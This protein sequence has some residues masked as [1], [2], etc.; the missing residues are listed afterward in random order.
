ME[1]EFVPPTESLEL[2]ELGFDDD[3]ICV[4]NSFNHLKGVIISSNN[5][6]Y[7]KKDK[8]DDRLPAP[9]ISQAFRFF[10]EKYNL[11]GGV[12]Y[13]AGTTPETTW[14][15]VYVIGHFNTN[16]SKMTMKYQPYEQ[17]ELECLRKLIEIVKEK[18]NG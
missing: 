7:I 11:I 15:D 18:Q 10:R 4:Y 5:G 3:T 1:K 2:K 9:T 12:E 14:W 13:I 6:D 16:T 8:W 17:A